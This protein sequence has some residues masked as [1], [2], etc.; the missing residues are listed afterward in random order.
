MGGASGTGSSFGGSS[1]LMRSSNVSLGDLE[2]ESLVVVLLSL[3]LSSSSFFFFFFLEDEKP[4]SQPSSS[5]GGASISFIGGNCGSPRRSISPGGVGAPGKP[6]M[7]PFLPF[8]V[9]LPML[10][11]ALPHGSSSSGF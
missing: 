5:T 7:T 11:W 3:P 10:N 2:A 8:L 1:R 6:P 4:R 9:F